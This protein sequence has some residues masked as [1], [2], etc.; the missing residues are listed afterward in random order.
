MLEDTEPGAER[1]ALEKKLDEL[2][3]RWNDT[4]QKAADHQALVDATLPE[5][6]KCSEAVEDLVPWLTETEG[7]IEAF[8]PL[9]ADDTVL[10]NR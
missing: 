1:D 8:P 2:K 6:E 3:S 5:A 9:A 10:E 7:K 4:K